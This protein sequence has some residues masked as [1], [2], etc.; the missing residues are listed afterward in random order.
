MQA[1]A[2]A[3]EVRL[4]RAGLK[5]AIKAGDV[6]VAEILMGEIPDWLREMRLEQLCKAIP[7]YQWRA[8]QRL[9]QET[10]TSLYVLVGKL[11]KRKRTVIAERLAEWEESAVSRRRARSRRHR[12]RTDS[13][14]R[15]A[16]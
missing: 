12:A 8:H 15:A 14:R 16:G 3:N 9:M 11:T 10:H 6:K 5:K 4:A 13:A 7:R 1:L 2:T